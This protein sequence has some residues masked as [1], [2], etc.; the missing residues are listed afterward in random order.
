MKNQGFTNRIND[1]A[2][3]KK[4]GKN[5]IFAEKVN[6]STKLAHD[7]LSGQVPK[8]E[9]LIKIS[10]AFNKSIDWLLTG[11]EPGR[12]IYTADIVVLNPD[13]AKKRVV[14]KNNEYVP[15]PLY[16]DPASLAR[17]I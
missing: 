17:H 12:P 15:L 9:I 8:W 3:E 1:L 7:I 10:E 6:I 16:H 14:S 11:K 4:W 5:T 2:G 13:E